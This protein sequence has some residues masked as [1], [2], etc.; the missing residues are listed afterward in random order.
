M[1]AGKGRS[2]ARGS[3]GI[4]NKGFCKI[5]RKNPAAK[6]SKNQANKKID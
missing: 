4:K 5:K 2:G 1:V 3:E 6:F